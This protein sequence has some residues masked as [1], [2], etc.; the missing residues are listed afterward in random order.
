MPGDQGSV[1]MSNHTEP[2]EAALDRIIE[3]VRH[4]GY[5]TGYAIARHG[6]EARD[7][8]IVAVPWT[9]PARGTQALIDALLRE[10]FVAEGPEGSDKPKLGPHG[11]ESW[12]LHGVWA[13]AGV[14]YIDLAIFPTRVESAYTEEKRQ[15]EE[16]LR[17][18]AR[19][20]R[21]WEA[22]TTPPE[23]DE[24]QEIIDET[25]ALLAGRTT[26]SSERSERP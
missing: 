25:N 9:E 11:R 7:F 14:Q 26:P 21:F 6:S 12:V 15:K 3:R 24:A 8:D 5:L 18:L 4:A 1:R 17:V 22:T 16:A 23:S 13:T 19:T 2:R 20:R 10:G